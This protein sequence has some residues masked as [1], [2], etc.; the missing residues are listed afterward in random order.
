MS[1]RK[2]ARGLLAMSVL[3]SLAG[4]KKEPA[5]VVLAAPGPEVTTPSGLRYQVLATGAGNEV[6]AGDKI[7]VHY[8]GTLVDGTKFDSSR[9][10]NEPFVFRVG[11]GQVIKG[12]DEGLIGMKRGDRRKLT[13]PPDLGYGSSGSGPIPANATL[14]FDVEL[15]DIR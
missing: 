4:C 5:P 9:D 11:Q 13:I 6:K 8:T 14:I 3:C 7:A 15:V 1:A 12:W 10:R 2:W